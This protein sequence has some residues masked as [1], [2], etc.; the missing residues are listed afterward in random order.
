MVIHQNATAET[1]NF[2]RNWIL[3]I[4]LV[5]VLLSPATSLAKLSVLSDYS[6]GFLLQ[7]LPEA[8]K[9]GLFQPVSLAVLKGAL[10][11]GLC[12]M[13]F[14]RCSRTA[15]IG[16]CL[17]LTIYQGMMKG[18]G[19][20]NHAEL[21][22]LFAVYIL[23]LFEWADYFYKPEDQ[24]FQTS[25]YGLPLT[26]ICATLCLAYT[27]I[28]L[29][30]VVFGGIDLFLGDSIYYWIIENSNEPKVYLFWKLDHLL[31]E[32][33]WLRILVKAGFPIFT[34]LE[35]F[36]LFALI[37]KPYR[38]VFIAGMF[39]FHFFIWL[40]MGIL[41][42]ENMLMYILFVEPSNRRQPVLKI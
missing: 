23:V 6:V 20:I 30:R 4:W 11:L 22:I 1:Y 40:F 21:G 27:F 12:C 24:E 37:H 10:V 34:G 2:F 17:L 13:I 19:E 18:I 3:G 42:W 29:H 33:D 14:R 32:Y 28:G 39:I 9:A 26:A 25:R 8:I 36:A 16:V 38:Y 15:G 35:I 41:F 7:Y 5:V 31:F